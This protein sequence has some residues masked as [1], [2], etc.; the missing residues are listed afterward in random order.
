[1]KMLIGGFIKA[2]YKYRLLTPLAVD[3]VS[4]S[5]GRLSVNNKA[6]HKGWGEPDISWFMKKYQL[7]F[8][9]DRIFLPAGLIFTTNLGYADY[10]RCTLK[11]QKVD[12]INYGLATCQIYLDK[13]I[14]P[15]EIEDV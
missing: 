14:I 8:K 12:N 2:H 5:E 9:H 11:I 4:F 7:V 1:M 13:E 10:N 15:F 3:E 6:L